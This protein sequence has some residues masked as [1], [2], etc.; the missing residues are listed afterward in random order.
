MLPLLAMKRPTHR[1]S[2]MSSSCHVMRFIL[3]LLIYAFIINLYLK[4]FFCRYPAVSGQGLIIHL[5]LGQSVSPCYAFM[6]LRAA[7]S[8]I[9]KLQPLKHLPALFRPACEYASQ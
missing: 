8:D 1:L 9:P 6:C 4:Q 5:N 3:I 7:F 2:C